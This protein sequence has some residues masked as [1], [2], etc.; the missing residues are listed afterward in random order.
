MTE[1]NS[2]NS[3]A[4]G[5]VGN[6]GTGFVSTPLTQY[7]VV[8]GASTSSTLAQVSGTGTT[9]QGLLSNGAGVAPTWQNISPGS[10]VLIQTQTASS[11]TSLNFT[12]GLSAYN[13]LIV[14]YNIIPSATNYFLCQVSTNGGSSYISS[15]YQCGLVTNAYNTTSFSNNTTGNTFQ[16]NGGTESTAGYGAAGEANFANVNNGNN[17]LMWCQGTELQG[18]GMSYCWT[19]GSCIAVNVN[20]LSFYVSGGGTIISGQIS[21]YG[22][23]Q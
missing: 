18:G 22:L 4:I 20:A 12:S 14:R 6:T 2:I 10:L 11:S 9:G 8:L 7:E 19:Q 13:H 23:V 17:I 5:I 15:G 16:I 1:A 21:V 3:S